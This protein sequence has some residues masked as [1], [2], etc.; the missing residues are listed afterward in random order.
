MGIGSKDA[1]KD[2]LYSKDTRQVHYTMT[3]KNH[4]WT[5]RAAPTY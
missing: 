1:L 3:D 2:T 4:F 5:R